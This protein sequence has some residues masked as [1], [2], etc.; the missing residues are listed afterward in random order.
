MC[1]KSE[2]LTVNTQ[3]EVIFGYHG[4]SQMLL[5][6]CYA[7]LRPAI[8]DHWL[9]GQSPFTLCRFLAL[10]AYGSCPDTLVTLSSTA[11]AHPHRSWVAMYPALFYLSIQ[12]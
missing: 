4:I 12:A 9:V 7:T 2:H 10:R 5:V 3:I 6:L 1:S 11:P 8:S